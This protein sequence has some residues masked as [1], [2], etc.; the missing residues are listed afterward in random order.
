[1]T[2]EGTETGTAFSVAP[3][4][5]WGNTDEPTIPQTYFNMGVRAGAS[6]G[7]AA[8]IAKAWGNNINYTK[9]YVD[10]DLY[11][12]IFGELK[13]PAES[14]D[15]V[16][17][18]GDHTSTGEPAIAW[19]GDSLTLN[20]TGQSTITSTFDETL[21]SSFE[22]F[23][24]AI[25]APNSAVTVTGSGTLTATSGLYDVV[26][27]KGGFTGYEK[28][29][30]IVF[31]VDGDAHK[32]TVSGRSDYDELLNEIGAPA[33]SNPYEVLTVPENATL[34]VPEA[35]TMVI[36]AVEKDGVKAVDNSGTLENN[37]EIA[38]PQKVDYYVTETI[39]ENLSSYL[40]KLTGT[41]YITLN[42]KKYTNSDFYSCN[43]QRGAEARAHEGVVCCR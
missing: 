8:V 26:T 1:M 10:I 15:A 12:L 21:D 40:G 4:F 29:N 3:V 28:L 16:T 2:A 13:T 39:I 17:V 11:N 37:G 35:K 25:Y 22:A 27:K 9:K 20:V 14:G 32:G 34:V 30:G 41:G 31:F 6:A 23:R 5:Y 24:A 36:Q 18:S 42:K 38:L 33:T 43:P 19:L 7:G